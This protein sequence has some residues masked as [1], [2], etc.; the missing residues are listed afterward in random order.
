MINYHLLWQSQSHSSATAA[1]ITVEHYDTS[2]TNEEM[3]PSE[4]S[5]EL[6]F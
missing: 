2:L 4:N 6:Y 1:L 5:Q 3:T